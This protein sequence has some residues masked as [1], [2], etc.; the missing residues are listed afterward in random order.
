[1]AEKR[2]AD[3]WPEERGSRPP[4]ARAPASHRVSRGVCAREEDCSPDGKGFSLAIGR[5]TY[6]D[7][8]DILCK[9][10]WFGLY[11]NF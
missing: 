6:N 8:F 3:S 10:V 9:A 7:R 4:T 2:G 11:C 1:V 5:R